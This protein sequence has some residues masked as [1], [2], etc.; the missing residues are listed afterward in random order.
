MPIPCPG[1]TFSNATS[2]TGTAACIMVPAGFWAPLGSALPYPCPAT[3]FYCPGAAADTSNEVPG[4]LPILMP[5]GGSVGEGGT[6]MTCPRGHW[7]TAGLVVA[8]PPNTYNPNEGSSFATSCLACPAGTA[9]PAASTSAA[10]CLAGP[11][12]GGGGTGGG[13]GGTARFGFA[14][15]SY[16]ISSAMFFYGMLQ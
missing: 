16:V 3:G 14:A 12:G 11:G 4:S 8:C 5:V 7:C 10:D 2:A 1:G 9:S 6:P 13:G 15:G